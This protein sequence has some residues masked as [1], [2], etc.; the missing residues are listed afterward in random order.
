LRLGGFEAISVSWG[1]ISM[2]ESRTKVGK[3][4]G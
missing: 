3:G 1:N 2:A 4:G